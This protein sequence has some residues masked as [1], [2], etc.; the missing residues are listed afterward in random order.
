MPIIEL[1][2]HHEAA[3][4]GMLA[5]FE[6]AGETD[7]PAYF[8]PFDCPYDT[9]LNRILAWARGEQLEPGWVPCTTFFFES[10]GALLGLYNFRHTLTPQLEQH[11]G[12]VGYSVRPSARGQGVATA[13][14]EHALGFGHG[15]GLTSLRLTC[16]ATN[17]ASQRVIEKAGGRLRD[18]YRLTPDAPLQ[19]RFD[20][21]TRGI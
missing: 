12:H 2:R 7:I 20:V 21:P 15:L 16:A 14:L 3:L 11:G 8:L 19:H 6:A 17:V 10:D 5:D 18:T 9:A 13:L 4:A 1:A